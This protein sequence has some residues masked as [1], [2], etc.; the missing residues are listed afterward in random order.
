MMK[1]N[2]ERTVKEGQERRRQS[3]SFELFSFLELLNFPSGVEQNKF[4]LQFT[5]FPACSLPSWS[6]TP[7]STG[8][9]TTFTSWTRLGV[10]VVNSVI[11]S[12]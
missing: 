4:E 10:V 7:F 1:E 6:P 2:E 3:A 5:N 11:V 8:F 12:F 9:P